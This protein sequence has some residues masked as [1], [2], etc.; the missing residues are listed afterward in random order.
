[1]TGLYYYGARYYDPRISLWLSPDILQEKYPNIS[2]YAYCYNNPVRFIDPDGCL[3]GDFLDENGDIIGSDGKKDGKLYA[4]KTTDKK[5]ADDVSGAGLSKGDR[6]KTKEFIKKNNGNTKAFD[7]DKIAY[8]NS[9]EIEGSQKIRE[10][11]SDIVMQDDG[12]GGSS[13][14]AN[15]REYG[16]IVNNDNTVEQQGPGPVKE[17]GVNAEIELSYYEY[18]MKSTFHSHPS[19]YSVSSSDDGKSSSVITFSKTVNTQS[20][21]QSPSPSDISNAKNNGKIN[22]VFGRSNNKVY[23]Y[24]GD[25]VQAVIPMSKFVNP[26]VKK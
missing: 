11:M 2:T 4:I 18:K 9:V 1:M 6:N 15:R 17:F 26:P 19:G 10:Q 8:T 3:A 20:Y 7:D 12:K 22:Y 16:G 5:F 14:E 21:T 24:N 13:N 25:G 23:I